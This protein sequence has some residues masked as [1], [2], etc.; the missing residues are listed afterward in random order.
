MDDE[1]I[2]IENEI[3]KEWLHNAWNWLCVA[4]TLLTVTFLILGGGYLFMC[5]LG[6]ME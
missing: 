1:E 3:A 2:D 4:A 6:W 5:A